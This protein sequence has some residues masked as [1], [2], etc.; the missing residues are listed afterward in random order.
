M[1][2]SKILPLLERTVRAL[3]TSERYEWGSFGA[4]N[5]GHLAQATTG[6]SRAELHRLG[7]VHGSDWSEVSESYCESSGLE[8]HAVLR[9][10]FAHGLEVDD[11]R[12]IEYL[13]NDEI[14]SNLPGGKRFL[15]RNVRED[16]LLYLRTWITLLRDCEREGRAWRAS[17]RKAEL[18]IYDSVPAHC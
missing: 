7:R 10:L 3:E 15:H 4:C 18:V 1:N 14:L 12:D 8:I 6:R 11:I 9:E 2:A 17:R 16:V 5:C 13:S